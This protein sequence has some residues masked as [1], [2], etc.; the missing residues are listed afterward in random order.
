VAKEDNMHRATPTGLKKNATDSVVR[1]ALVLA[2]P[3]LTV[4]WLADLVVPSNALPAGF[5]SLAG[6]VHDDQPPFS[7]RFID[8]LDNN[9][10]VSGLVQLHSTVRGGASQLW[11]ERFPTHGTIDVI[12]LENKLTGQCLADRTDERGIATI[13]PCSD[14]TTLWQK[15]PVGSGTAFCK[16]NAGV[17]NLPKRCLGKYIPNPNLV[18][19]EFLFVL[20]TDNN[21]VFNYPGFVWD[22]RKPPDADSP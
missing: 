13:R 2:I 8:V 18:D 19:R 9:A 15:I 5:F 3:I 21:G 4:A 16:N 10:K 17:F 20:N 6:T 14:E 11:K 12:K 22:A 1:T 7:L